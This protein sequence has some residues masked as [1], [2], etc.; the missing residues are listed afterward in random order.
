MN[1]HYR[2]YDVNK[3]VEAVTNQKVSIACEIATREQFETDCH[4]LVP[5]DTR[6]I[7]L[8]AD[9]N[10]VFLPNGNRCDYDYVKGLL[11]ERG[12]G[13]SW[14]LHSVWITEPEDEF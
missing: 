13:K 12:Y 2:P 6:V 4:R 14:C 7:H 3:K 11:K 5:M 8:K 10:K 1:I 9:R